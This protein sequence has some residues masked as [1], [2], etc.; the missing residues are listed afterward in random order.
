V[1]HTHPTGGGGGGGGGSF[2][3]PFS[4]GF[5]YDGNFPAGP[6]TVDIV[7]ITTRI[8]GGWQAQWTPPVT[9]NQ[10][11]ATPQP[12]ACLTRESWEQAMKKS[13]SLPAGVFGRLAVSDTVPPTYNYQ[14]YLINLNGS[15][16]K[17]LGFGDSPFFSPDGSKI[18]HNGS[19]ETGPSD[20]L[21]ITDLATGDTKLLPGTA[22]GDSG[23]I[24]SPDGTQIAFTRG[25]ASGLIGAPGTS[26][27][28]LTDLDG[29][30]SR[31][32]TDGKAA[33]SA[34]AWMPDGKHLLYGVAERD[35]ASLHI[36]DTQT[37]ADNSL[38][39][40]NYNGTVSVSPDGKR[41]AFEEMLPLEKYGLTVSDLD[42]SNRVQL[43][44]GDPYITTLPFWSPDGNWVV[45]SVQDPDTN[46]Q[47]NPMLA[48]I[49]VDTCQVIP[50]PT[51][52]GYV[53][54][55]LP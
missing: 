43:A 9:S 45:A 24:W 35:G 16:R 27:I 3:G 40:I 7:S 36:M 30:N 47:P 46:K 29:S 14:M 8:S 34:K 39:E 26:D 31:Q 1:D 49:G 2:S 13:P 5:M 41:V 42:G 20:G 6:I 50:L 4:A 51:L 55:W 12:S 54:S 15:D 19:S 32:L 44:D 38:F 10:V 18:V 22:R 52:G 28:I 17:A 11:P 21:F 33:Y 25:S 23:P 53:T 48:L 37:G